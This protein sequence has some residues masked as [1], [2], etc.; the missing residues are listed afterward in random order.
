MTISR[1]AGTLLLGLFTGLAFA[2]CGAGPDPGPSETGPAPN[3]VE[4]DAFSVAD[5]VGQA[6]PAAQGSPSVITLQPRDALDVPVPL[7]PVIMD[8]FGRDFIPRLIVVREGQQV[9]FKNSE[10]DLHTVHVQDSDG[11]SLFNVAMPIRGGEHDHLFGQ[12]GD[13][14]VSCNAHQEMH[15]TILVVAAPYAV[16]A[17]RNGGFA[18]PGVIPGTYDLSL[19]RG[20]ERLEQVVEIVAGPNELSLDFP[21]AG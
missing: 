12:A 9:L 4:T 16:V 6:P 18:L 7:D 17:D 8:Q 1:A 21:P 5:V 10:D 2:G 3:G 20:D 11:E 13:Y 15:A 14:E 19:R